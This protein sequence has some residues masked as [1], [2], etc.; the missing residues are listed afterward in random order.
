ML[1]CFKMTNNFKWQRN[2]NRT[3]LPMVGVIQGV[4]V[5]HFACEIVP[6]NRFICQRTF[7]V[8]SDAIGM[9]KYR[10]SLHAIG[11]LDGVKL[12]RYVMYEMTIVW[13][14]DSVRLHFTI[15]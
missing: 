3:Q 12:L 13:L 8:R 15:P 5:W 1:E 4:C 14:L 9:D 2:Q 11:I 7:H 10:N 6:Q